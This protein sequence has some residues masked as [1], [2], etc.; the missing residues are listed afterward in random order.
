MRKFDALSVGETRQSDFVELSELAIRA[1]AEQFD[2]QWF[3][4]DPEAAKASPFNG[5]IAS[6]AHLI[7]LWR[8]IDHE[9]NGDIAY[10]CGVGMECVK[11]VRAVRAGERISLRSE[12]VALRP[13]STQ[14][15]RG[16]ATIAYVMSNQ[17]GHTVMTLTAL[18]LVYR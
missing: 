16:L 4:L 7:A 11:F 15:E 17:D 18:N 10:Q 6:G 12:I 14:A 9:I 13:S 3:H 5:L 8:R 2:P 1:F